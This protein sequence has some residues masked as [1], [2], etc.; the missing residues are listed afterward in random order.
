MNRSASS[1]G[2]NLTSNI[3]A[4]IDQVR[5]RKNSAKNTKAKHTEALYLAVMKAKNTSGLDTSSPT[6]QIWASIRW[7]WCLS[8][9]ARRLPNGTPNRPDIID[10]MPNLY[11]TLEQYISLFTFFTVSN[12]RKSGVT[13]R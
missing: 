7:Y 13:S 11:A 4:T 9:W 12:L 2:L 10:M 3:S 8:L 1:T 5:F 6:A